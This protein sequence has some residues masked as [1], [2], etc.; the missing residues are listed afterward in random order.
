MKKIV[1]VTVF[2]VLFFSC[3][4]NTESTVSD[5]FILSFLNTYYKPLANKDK[6]LLFIIPNSGCSGCISSIEHF[7]LENEFYKKTNALIIFTNIKDFKAFK[8]R[9]EKYG[10]LSF[11]NVF[12][13]KKNMFLK[14]GFV[15]FYPEFLI[16]NN[17]KI[18]SRQ[19]I[20]PENQKVY[21]TIKDNM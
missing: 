20:E 14:N 2:G 7:L 8:N 10:F 21:K 13:D 9:Y 17:A 19:F 5:D 11:K 3:K 18:S 15:S 16:I 6:T 4:N 1:L 12:V